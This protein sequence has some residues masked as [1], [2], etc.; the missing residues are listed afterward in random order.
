MV[1]TEPNGCPRNQECESRYKPVRI[2]AGEHFRCIRH[3]GEVRRDVN[4]V[5]RKQGHD[6]NTQQPLWKSLTKSPGQALPCHHSDSGTH[7]LNRGHQRPHQECSTEKFGSI[8]S[9]A[10]ATEYVAMPDGSSSAA[11]VM[12]PGPSDFNSNRLHRAGANI[13]TKG[14]GRKAPAN[15]STNPLT[16]LHGALC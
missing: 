16:I 14:L 7:H 8:P 11:P 1:I 3:A 13:G 2:D 10:P 9:C 4:R 5:G 15:H 6:E 12:T